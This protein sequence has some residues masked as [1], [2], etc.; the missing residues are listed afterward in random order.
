VS[1]P[2]FPSAGDYME[3]I[4]SPKACFSLAD[5]R[6]AQPIID[7]LGLPAVHAGNFAYV[8]KLR[9][10]TGTEIAARCFARFLGDRQ[11][12]YN[13]MSRYVGELCLRC[14]AGFA[15]EPR[16]IRVRGAWYPLL[17]MDWVNGIPLNRHVEQMVDDQAALRRLSVQWRQLVSN[18]ERHRIAHGDLQHGNVLVEPAT[19][20][21]RLV[22]YDAMWV[23]SFVNG[24][25]AAELGHRN[26]QHPARS[27]S[28]FG[29]NLDRFSA[30]VI[31]TAIRAL[32]ERSDLWERYDNG[33]NLLFVAADFQEPSRSRLLTELLELP[34]PLPDLARLLRWCCGIDLAR[35][36]ALPSFAAD[37]I[38]P[39]NASSV[40][41]LSD[42]QQ[43]HGPSTPDRF[44]SRASQRPQTLLG[45]LRARLFGRR[46]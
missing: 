34:T 11:R 16:G 4:Q 28:D 46:R 17:R 13:T 18:L 14:L 37:P 42:S 39:R 12:R 21:L 15:Y 35:I 40:D 25:G 33:E 9:L 29:P 2:K 8:F 27:R 24:L 20:G 19:G 32:A 6:Q 7:P 3:A 45:R 22:D 36:P 26:F 31:Y 5:L 38:A 43:F 23:P 41:W 1:Q 10:A 30:L 44:R